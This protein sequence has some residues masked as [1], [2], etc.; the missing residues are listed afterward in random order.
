[1]DEFPKIFFHIEKIPEELKSKRQWLNWKYSRDDKG[2]MTKIPVAPYLGKTTV[3]AYD[4][5]NLTTFEIAVEHARKLEMGIGF[6]FFTGSR[7]SGIDLDKLDDETAE[8]IK[9]AGSYTEYSPSGRGV[10]ILGYGKAESLKKEEV[11]VYSHDRFFTVTGDILESAPKELGNIQPVLDLITERYGDKPK[12]ITATSPEVKTP[13]GQDFL[14]SYGW[15]LEYLRERDPKLDRLLKDDN[16]GYPSP[17]EGDLATLSKL[18]FWGYSESEAIDVLRTFRGREKLNRDDYIRGTLSKI[19]LDKTITDLVDVK[20]W[21]PV[22]GYKVEGLEKELA[23]E[24]KEADDAANQKEVVEPTQLRH[25]TEIENPTNLNKLVRVDVI[26]A[27]TT[28]A[29]AIPSK[30]LGEWVIDGNPGSAEKTISQKSFINMAL[31]GATSTAKSKLLNSLFPEGGGKVTVRDLEYRTVYGL[32]VRPPVFSIEKRDGKLVDD[33]GFEYKGFSVYIVTDKKQ[34]FQASALLRLTGWVYPDP[35]TQKTTLLATEVEFPEAISGYDEEKLNNLRSAFKNKKPAQ[36]LEWVFD[37]FE[38]YSRIIGRRN[39]AKATLLGFFT[40]IWV[41]IDGDEEQ[42]GWCNVLILGDTTTAKTETVRKAIKLLS[43]G[44]IITAETATS[45]GLVGAAVQ[46]DNGG[47]SI[48][49]GALVLNDRRLLAVD[50]AHKLGKYQLASLAEAERSGTVSIVKA[51]KDSAYARTRQI[52]IA[53]PLD[54][55][56]RRMES[57]NLS[58]FYY[59]AQ[60]ISTFLDLMSI[61]RLDLV[62]LADADDVK[63]EAINKP[64][65][66]EP[67][68]ALFNLSESLKLVWG[69]K[70]VLNYTK[71][72]QA[73]IN[74][75][76]TALYND[77]F[78]KTIPIAS[79]DLKWKL[80]RLSAA[81]AALSLSTKDYKS[82]DIEAEHVDWVAGFMRDEYQNAGLLS[83]A[84]RSRFDT[85]TDEQ[86]DETV[87]K[88]ASIIDKETIEETT[89]RAAEILLWIAETGRFTKDSL[90]IQF[91]LAEKNELR[92]LISE[93][94]TLKLVEVGSGFYSTSK[95]N[96]LCKSTHFA[97]IAMIATPETR[98][99]SKSGEEESKQ[100]LKTTETEDNQTEIDNASPENLGVS[101]SE[102]GKEGNQGKTEVRYRDEDISTDTGERTD[103]P[104]F[105]ACSPPATHPPKHPLRNSSQEIGELYPVLVD[106]ETGDVLDGRNRLKANPN[107][108]KESVKTEDNLMRLKIKHHANWHRKSIDRQSVLTEI[109]KETG[110]HGLKPYA[111]FLDVSE[112]TISTYLP[113]KYKDAL[114]SQRASSSAESPSAKKLAKTTQI[115]GEIEKEVK[116]S[117]IV[118]PKRREIISSLESVQKTLSSLKDEPMFSLRSEDEVESWLKEVESEYSLWECL[119]ERPTGYGDPSFHGNCNPIVIYGLLSRYAPE[120]SIV[121]DPMA[122]SGTFID[123]A[124]AMGYSNIIA[125]DLVPK[126]EDIGKGDAEKTELSDKS[127]DFVFT[128]FPY[129]KLIEYSE[130]EDAD[131]NGSYLA[132]PVYGVELG[133]PVLFSEEAEPASKIEAEEADAKP[134][135]DTPAENEI[136]KAILLLASDGKLKPLPSGDYEILPEKVS[137][138]LGAISEVPKNTALCDKCFSQHRGAKVVGKSLP[139]H[140]CLECG[141]R[142]TVIAE[143]PDE[144]RA[145]EKKAIGDLLP[146]L[147]KEWTSGYEAD[148][149]DIC[150]KHGWTPEEGEKLFDQQKDEG[151]ILRYPDGFWRWVK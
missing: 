10:H 111:D 59:P 43:A 80:A 23:P 63:P 95:L 51:A 145:G 98:H 48:D 146:V 64:D 25:I 34:D 140:V 40:P 18:L 91:N 105:P 86:I 9:L 11:E 151:K 50:G 85:P 47:W 49:W 129:W 4:L 92:P 149:I 141:D 61:A 5:N 116:T 7:I 30:I 31:P 138:K 106:A 100:D 46:V 115:L 35:K 33:R 114:Q 78:T 125:R 75:N 103:L 134:V 110:W 62:V 79:I 118:E 127:I 54:P 136:P 102:E 55:Q 123:I 122:G 147:R 108:H 65:H 112:R 16:S 83:L 94:T 144:Q 137:P 117:M 139:N 57:K 121:F 133:K 130:K 71:E 131:L 32:R 24:G 113:Q 26:V 128:H 1:M 45:V 3:S 58:E 97:T 135:D 99:P 41:N 143:I 29:Y 109:A 60:A 56:S 89:T 21:N 36:I 15:K 76:A 104:I 27:S 67:D 37:N 14:N 2:N 53:N 68:P 82:L 119:N 42:R 70:M 126:R 13:L 12:L 8:I 19:S 107:W 88:I 66:E 39:I 84:K 72:A 132:V 22:T 124:K 6:S 81:A 96:R 90:R 17:S 142:A 20:N 87:G 52:K 120:N 93:L 77:F 73:S 69:E 28:V 38:K 44:T 101:Y 74:G 148:F 150:V